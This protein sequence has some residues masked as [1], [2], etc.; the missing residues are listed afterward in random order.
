MKSFKTDVVLQQHKNL[1]YHLITRTVHDHSAH[2]DLFQEVFL[3]IFKSLSRFEGRSKL[4]TW[5]SKLTFN[6]CFNYIRKQNNGGIDYPLSQWLEERGDI[7][8]ADVLPSDDCEKKDIKNRINVAMEGL[9]NKYK[10]PLILF[11]FEHF[12]YQQIAEV[13]E[14]PIGTVKSNIFRGLKY[15]KKI[16]GGNKDEFL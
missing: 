10:L 1:V 9:K 16:M 2:E 15:L 5:I 3:Q 14:M 13:L 12:S 11:Y 7:A 4:S 8:A 6:T